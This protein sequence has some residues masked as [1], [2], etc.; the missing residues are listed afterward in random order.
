MSDDLAGLGLE[1]PGFSELPRTCAGCGVE[2]PDHAFA[3]A[4]GRW[5]RQCVECDR[6]HR[7]ELRDGEE[8]RRRRDAQGNVCA[9]CCTAP[10]TPQGFA[11]LQIDHDHR[12]G[13]VRGLLCRR[14]NLMLGLA[15]DEIARLYAAIAYLKDAVAGRPHEPRTILAERLSNIEL[16][17]ARSALRDLFDGR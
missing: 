7:Y 15:D 12:T 13:R 5:V 3:T 11:E 8:L 17:V 10:A 2:L 1:L 9:I 16:P 14:C 4:D 6:A